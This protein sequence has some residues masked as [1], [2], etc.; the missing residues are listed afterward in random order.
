MDGPQLH[1]LGGL[2]FNNATTIHAIMWLRD[3]FPTPGL[4]KR[5]VYTLVF[6]EKPGL[7]WK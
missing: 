7:V 1:F 5:H 6:K 3:F 2:K 4:L